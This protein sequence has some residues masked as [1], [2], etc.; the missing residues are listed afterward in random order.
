MAVK[1]G[2]VF[3]NL[4]NL[5][6]GIKVFYWIIILQ[7]NSK[8]LLFNMKKNVIDQMTN[9]IDMSPMCTKNV[10]QILKFSN[11]FKSNSSSSVI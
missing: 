10:T 3:H 8:A 5:G 1:N 7:K 11:N 4:V 9:S 6:I 2:I